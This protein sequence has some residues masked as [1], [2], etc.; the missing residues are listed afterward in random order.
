MTDFTEINLQTL[1][2]R[3]ALSDL[4]ND[5]AAGVDQRDWRL[6]RSCFTDDLEADFTGVVPGNICHGADKWVAAAVK[7]IEPL[8]VTQHLITNHVHDIEGDIA[9]TRSYLQAQH[10]QTGADGKPRHFLIGGYYNYDMVRTDQGWKIK[11]YSLTQTWCSGDPSVLVPIEDH[12][13]KAG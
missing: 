3:A 6:F 12:Q 5:Y 10:V 13:K 8:A 7:L 11:K 9:R 1:K 4:L 2:D